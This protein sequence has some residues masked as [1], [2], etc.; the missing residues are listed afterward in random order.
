MGRGREDCGSFCHGLWLAQAVEPPR[1]IGLRGRDNGFIESRWFR[2]AWKCRVSVLATLKH[3]VTG[4]GPAHPEELSKPI[5]FCFRPACLMAFYLM[6][7]ERASRGRLTGLVEYFRRTGTSVRISPHFRE[8]G[9]TRTPMQS[10]PRAHDEVPP[11]V[12][13]CERSTLCCPIWRGQLHGFRPL[14]TQGPHGAPV[15]TVE[16]PC[17]DGARGLLGDSIQ[18]NGGLQL[19][20]GRAP[21]A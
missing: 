3:P 1:V 21:H 18:G 5:S 16:H 10:A 6:M 13:H 9:I 4:K 19:E 7:C 17:Q 11:R 20:S 8:L 2:Y 12:P 14:P 15:G